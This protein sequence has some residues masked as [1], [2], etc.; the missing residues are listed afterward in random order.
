[1][2]RLR[3]I[4]RSTSVCLLRYGNLCTISSTVTLWCRLGIKLSYDLTKGKVSEEDLESLAP[5]L[6]D[7]S[8]RDNGEWDMHCPL[9]EDT[10]R[11]ASLNIRKG[12]WACLAGCGGGSV[13]D[14]IKCRED[15]VDPPAEGYGDMGG[16]SQ[17]RPTDEKPS[18]K[19]IR[20][21]ATTLRRNRN[22]RRELLR[23]RGINIKTI[24]KYE[25]GYDSKGEAYRIPI[26]NHDGGIWNVRYYQ[27]DPPP[28][29]RKM[30]SVNGMGSPRLYPV[31]VLERDPK[32]IIICEGEFDALLAIQHGYAAITRTGAA[33]V[34]SAEWDKHFKGRTVYLAHDADDKGVKANNAL[35]FRLGKV[36]EAVYI[37]EW[38]YPIL[39]KHGKDLTDFI[40]EHGGQ[41]LR[42]L[43]DQARERAKRAKATKPKELDSGDASL[44]D[45]FD[46]R[47]VG[48]PLT[49]IS[50]IVGKQEPGYSVPRTVKETCDMSKGKI[51]QM[52]PLFAADG[53][54]SFEIPRNDPFILGMKDAPSSVLDRMLKERSGVPVRCDRVQFDI[55]DYWAL[56]VLNGRVSVDHVR[57]RSSAD[58]RTRQIIGV[59]KHD[60]M[61]NS[62]IRVEGS[63][64]PE[65]RR[66]TNAFLAWNV[67]EQET[68][69]D[70]FDVSKDILEMLKTFR[71]ERGQTP[72]EK[73][74]EIARDLSANV[75]KIYNREEMHVAMDLTFHSLLHFNFDGTPL[76]RGWMQLLVAGDTRTGKSEVASRLLEHYRMGEMVSCESASLAGILGGVH[77][78]GG[79]EEWTINWGV[80]PLN[81]RRLVVLDEFG[82]LTHDDI[83]HLSSIRSSGEAQL[84]KISSGQT[85]ACTRLI[86]LAN[87]PSKDGMVDYTYGMDAIKPIVGAPEDIARFDLVMT[88][89][90]DDV[91][92][93]VI[94][95]PH[96]AGRL[97]YES[98]LCHTLLLWAWSRKRSQVRFTDAATS[99]VYRFANKLGA[100]YI[101]DPPLIQAADIRIKLARF[102]AALASSTFSTDDTGEL[103]VV[104][105]PHVRDSVKFINRIYGDEG[106]GY[107]ARSLEAKADIIEARKHASA[108]RRYL[109]ENPSLRKF[110]KGSSRFKRQDI[111]EVTGHERSTANGIINK[112]HNYRMIKKEAG[113]VI[114]SPVLHEILREKE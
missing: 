26:R 62:T 77:K 84:T 42:D 58:Y 69:L 3:S 63:L 106:F 34:W 111:E 64:H 80:I 110:L 78:V 27:F 60:T 44:M 43:M 102:S 68:S 79:S 98:D 108:A 65:P 104:K 1:M 18:D 47:R 32:E 11:S 7:E 13:R 71:P 54:D 99:A 114:I 49:F 56:E 14:L 90:K 52:C 51:C 4:L 107:L 22:L 74:V 2:V 67:E 112:L 66:Q 45:T 92:R 53:I 83:A 48:E 87:P 55:K 100:T 23:K 39:P 31:E 59:G 82:E 103:V 40:K 9:H 6:I 12:V 93:S 35:M 73:R 15:W 89:A 41:A 94:N 38:P 109:K 37:I 105:A 61:P 97:L 29:K 21:W 46:S 33:D 20:K 8:P 24:K 91:P 36:A 81:H 5:Y 76:T 30:W 25:L 113:F 95:R 10:T 57:D 101:E 17:Q 70:K 50:T 88:V 72:L 28:G 19:L 75:T 16:R 96:P 86:M 85:A